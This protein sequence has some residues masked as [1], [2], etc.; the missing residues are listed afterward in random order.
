MACCIEYRWNGCGV[1][2]IPLCPNSSSVLAFGVAVNAKK[3]RFFDSARAA[4][5]AANT[6]SASMVPPSSRSSTPWPSGPL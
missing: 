1:P 6:S 2:S 3:D 5:S 4:I